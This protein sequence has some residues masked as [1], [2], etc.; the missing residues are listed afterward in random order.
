MVLFLLAGCFSVPDAPYRI[1]VATGAFSSWGKR[2]LCV[3]LFDPLDGE[4]RLDCGDGS[5]GSATLILPIELN[6]ANRRVTGTASAQI[7]M[8]GLNA[9]A[10][11]GGPVVWEYSNR[12]D[13]PPNTDQPGSNRDI[14]VHDLILP[15]VT[16][17]SPLDPVEVTLEESRLQGAFVCTDN[18]GITP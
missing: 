1:A 3:C 18:A 6:A 11:T 2:S 7:E 17:S 14:V 4:A 5:V 15:A 13:E 16:V 8:G 9:S 10:F 12:F